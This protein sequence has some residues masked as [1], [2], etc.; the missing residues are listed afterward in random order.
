MVDKLKVGRPS[1]RCAPTLGTP[2]V[3]SAFRDNRWDYVYEFTARRAGCAS[4]A[5]SPSTSRTT[6]SRAGK[7]TRCRSRSS[8]L[9]RVAGEQAAAAA[10]RDSDDQ[11][12]GIFGKI[13]DWFKK[14]RSLGS[15]AMMAIRVAIAG[16]GGRMG[17]ALIDAVARRRPTARSPP[18]STS[19]AVRRIGPRRRRALR[20]RHRRRSWPPTSMPRSRAADV[21]IDFTR[22][23]GTLAHL[24]ACARHGVAAVVGTTGPRRRAEGDARR[25]RGA[26]SRSCSRRT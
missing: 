19:P 25:A 26:R 7:A 4:T 24:A 10:A 15:R 1:R 23:A 12:A 20:P 3:T 21:L 8:E 18:R 13:I 17:Q 5:S 22:P 11:D 6:S 16:A 9:N 14:V 2:L